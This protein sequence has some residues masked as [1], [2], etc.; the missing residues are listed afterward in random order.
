MDPEKPLFVRIED[1]THGSKF[2]EQSSGP[3]RTDSR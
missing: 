2:R 1:T 3:E